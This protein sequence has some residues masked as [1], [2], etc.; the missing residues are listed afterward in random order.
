MR[1]VKPLEQDIY[2]PGFVATLFDEMSTSYGITNYVSSFGFCE[3]WRRQAVE[4]VRLHPGMVVV[5]LMSGMGECWR[6]IRGHLNGHGQII[7]MDISF[8]MTRRACLNRSRFFDASIDVRQGDALH[9]Q[10]A[11]ASADCVVA[12]F[13]L[14]TFSRSQIVHLSR[15]VWRILKPG[16]TFS[17]VEVAVPECWALRI[18]YLLYLRYAIPVL[19]RVFLGNPDNYRMLA[20]YTELFAS[21]DTVATSLQQQGFSVQAHN[22]FFG[23][24]RRMSGEKPIAPELYSLRADTRR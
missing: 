13:G 7:A 4:G 24:A 15:E 2:E 9:S 16:G 11:D 22:L 21:G 6:F 17:F 19:G 14:K 5:D 3:R 10:P 23:C 1:R 12:C 20:V 18:P 8:E